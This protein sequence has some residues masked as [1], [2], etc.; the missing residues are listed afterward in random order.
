MD[1]QAALPT[2]LPVKATQLNLSQWLL[3][4]VLNATV[5]GRKS[6]DTLI[7][8]IQSQHLEAKTSPDKVINVGEQLKLLVAKLGDPVVLRV[9]QQ[10]S[11]KVVHEIKQQLLRESMPKQ[12]SMEKLTTVLNQVSKNAREVIKFFPA[13]VEQQFKKLIE[14]L[15]T[16]TNLNNEI[17]L[18]AAIKNSGVFFESKL[19]AEISSKKYSGDLF[20]TTEQTTKQT[21]NQISGQT[22]YQGTAKDLKANL[23]LLSGVTNKYKQQI[24]NQGNNFIKQA[25]TILF[26]ET[27]KKSTAKMENSV[28]TTELTLKIDAETINKQVESSIA[29][30]EVNQS[31]AIIAQDNQTPVWSFEIPVKDKQDIDLVKLNIQANEES[32]SRDKK[33]KLW[34]ANLKID[35]EGIGAVSAKLSIID[36]EVNATLWSENEI[37]NELINDNL[38]L[39]NKQIEKCGLSTGKII[40]LEEAPAVQ[41][42]QFSDHN[43]INITI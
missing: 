27:M 33:E 4:Q 17:G 15:P 2:P 35:F 19:L 28:R 31:K 43:L 39:L 3:G 5:T 20:K 1:I 12:A 8:Q 24:Q 7:L 9:L 30:I 34:T 13:P 11:A 42:T 37:L 40:C 18:K 22:Q 14:H 10:D 26:F 25:Q 41:E 38:F 23:L 32:K 21:P 6:A 36:K 16:K 29:R